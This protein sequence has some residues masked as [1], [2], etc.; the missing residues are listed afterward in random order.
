MIL[1]KTGFPEESEI[2]LCTVT[3]V[4]HHSVF[5]KLNEYDKT[6]MIHIS[7]VSPGRIR[8]IR[9]FVKE[10]KVIA[11][12]VLRVN[13]ERGHI[14]LSLRRVSEGQRRN[15]VN[16]AKQQ[17][18]AEKIIEIA[19]KK[20]G[21]D[22]KKLFDETSEKLLQHYPSLFSC[23]AE[24][25]AGKASFDGL[26]KQVAKELTEVIEERLKPEEVEVKGTLKLVSYSP[27]GVE[28]VKEALKKAVSEGV[29]VKYFGAGKYKVEV[30]APDY[31]KAEQAIQKAT[32]SAI[33]YIKGVGGEG[34]FE[35]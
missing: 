17:Q 4:Q 3:S 24:V 12:K 9:D 14:D 1:R 18:K 5:V 32:S 6:G 26:P 35:K 8:N 16:E 20:L 27:N 30:K 19:A 7:E 22:T 15:K 29:S 10:G 28:E 11:C 2:V 21:V 33:S 31:K 34:S 25:A 13:K 23:F